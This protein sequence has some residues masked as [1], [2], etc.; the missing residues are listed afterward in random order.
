M[1]E[2]QEPQSFPGEAGPS[3][4][5]PSNDNAKGRHIA[6]GPLS[7]SALE[8]P[9]TAG[10]DRT[11]TRYLWR[12]RFVQLGDRGLAQALSAIE[13]RRAQFALCES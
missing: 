6:T 7:S 12:E 8:R 4:Q 11:A 13:E 9:C 3:A 10:R 5:A 2:Y 1:I